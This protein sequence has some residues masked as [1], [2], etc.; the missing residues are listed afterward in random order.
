MLLLQAF[1]VVTVVMAITVIADAGSVMG[2]RQELSALADQAAIAGAQ[3]LDAASYYSGGTDRAAALPLDGAAVGAAVAR[4]LAPT[5]RSGSVPGL[6]LQSVQV[7]GGE[8]A[9]RLRCTAPLP[10]ASAIGV[11][12]VP[13]HA[14]ASAQLLIQSAR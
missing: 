3:A 8:V 10:F 1:L 14:G 9:V 13:V 2:R 11:D 5:I 12:S 7:A 6:E 4:Y